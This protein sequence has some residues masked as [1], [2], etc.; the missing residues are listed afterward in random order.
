MILNT[1][2]S[3]LFSTNSCN[4]KTH[5]RKST[6]FKRT[7]ESEPVR[8]RLQKGEFVT[9]HFKSSRPLHPVF[10]Y[11]SLL[12]DDGHCILKLD[13]V[14]QAGQEDVGHANQAVV[15]LLIEERVGTL[16]IRPHHLGMT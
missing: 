9:F 13:V 5:Q 11:L 2:S 14:E 12:V 4:I 15:L 16:E 10:S 7:G 8:S 6:R 1:S 3:V